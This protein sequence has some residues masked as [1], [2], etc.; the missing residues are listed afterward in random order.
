MIWAL[1]KVLGPRNSAS[2]IDFGQEKDL[3]SN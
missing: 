1:A 3:S 2:W